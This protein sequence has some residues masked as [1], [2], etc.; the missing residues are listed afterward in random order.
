MR[1]QR[2]RICAEIF[3]VGVPRL[4]ISANQREVNA[5]SLHSHKLLDRNGELLVGSVGAALLHPFPD[6]GALGNITEAEDVGDI[7]AIGIVQYV[8][9]YLYER[10]VFGILVNVVVVLVFDL[11]Y[12]SAFKNKLVGIVSDQ[13]LCITHD[14]KGIIVVC[15]IRNTVGDPK[16]AR[17][18]GV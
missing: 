2:V 18:S 15:G 12:I 9:V 8:V 1:V 10:I 17:R 7:F 14:S 11:I 4:V 3:I 5:S 13:L 16:A 6:R